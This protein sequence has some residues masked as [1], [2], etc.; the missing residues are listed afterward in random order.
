[1][2]KIKFIISIII[3][4]L[5]TGIFS[6]IYADDEAT[7]TTTFTDFAN[8]K[9]ILEE[10]DS[11]SGFEYKLKVTGITFNED[12]TYAVFL[13][14]GNNKPNITSLKDYENYDGYSGYLE[15]QDSGIYLVS[16]SIEKWI[17]K[18]GDLYVWII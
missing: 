8:A 6:S 3:F 17:E 11:G 9:V 14:N 13:T 18:N 2:K 7:T 16:E 12:S 5:V 15:Q 4:I 10:K 1:M